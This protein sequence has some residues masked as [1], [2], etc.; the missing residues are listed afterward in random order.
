MA[1]LIYGAFCYVLFLLTFSYAVGFVGNIVVPKSIDSGSAVSS[2]EALVVDLILLGLFAIQHSVMARPAFKRWWTL[3]VPRAMER[4]TYVL[5]SLVLILLFWQWRPIREVIWLV[6][7]PTGSAILIA[8]FGI[9]W[10][11]VLVSTF[12]ISHFDLFGLQQV[13]ANWQGTKYRPPDVRTPLFYKWMRHPLYFGFLLA[14][15]STPMM[16]A[17]HLLFALATSGYIF[18]GIQLE[19][20]DL[21]TFHGDAYVRYRKQVSMIV[22]LPP[23]RD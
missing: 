12:L 17:G 16:T 21:I 5:S 19:E 3:F 18:I 11:I 7:N 23:K 22:P 15:W 10:A 14:F 20:H 8:L 9:G 2:I 4:S 6:Y 1:G 13:F